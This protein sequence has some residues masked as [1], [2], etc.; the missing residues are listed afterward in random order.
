MPERESHLVI[1]FKKINDMKKIVERIVKSEGAPLETDIWL[2]PSTG[3][4]RYFE[5]GEWNVIAGGGSGS[6][7]QIQSDWNQ[8]DDTKVDYIKNKPTIPANLLV[9]G[10]EDTD[11]YEY[12]IPDDNQPTF[13]EAVNVF[14][15]GGTV[16]IRVGYDT[17]LTYARAVSLYPEA[18]G[19]PGGLVFFVGSSIISWEDPSY[20][21]PFV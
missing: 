14:L 15:N 1:H 9:I 7:A 20:D 11:T 19:T 6:S 4:L 16:T 3:E 21:N 8:S 5:N 2:K 12:F 18:S 10:Q 13:E 17:Y